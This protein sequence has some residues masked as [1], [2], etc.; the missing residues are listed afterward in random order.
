[1]ISLHHSLYDGE[2]F[3][4]LLEDVA[5]RYAESA[6][7]KRGSPIAF[8]QHVYSQDPQASQTHWSQALSGCHPTIFNAESLPMESSQVVHRTF[9]KTLSDIERCSARLQTTVPSFIQTFLPW[10]WLMPSMISM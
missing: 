8:I 10:S 1:M 7:A 6:P 4:M 2:S 5:T 9:S 3:G